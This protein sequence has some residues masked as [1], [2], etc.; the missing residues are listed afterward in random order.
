MKLIILVKS[1]GR[2]SLYNSWGKAVAISLMDSAVF[3][4]FALVELVLSMIFETAPI[5]VGNGVTLVSVFLTFIITV[6]YFLIREPLNLGILRWYY[7]I[8][9]GVSEEI[10]NIFSV[11]ASVKQYFR[12]L[13]LEINVWG[14]K[15]IMACY[16]F[17]FPLLLFFVSSECLDS[18]DLYMSADLS[19]IIG[20]AGCLFSALAFVFAFILFLIHKQ[21][22]FLAR[23]YLVVGGLAPIEA[24]KKSKH[25]SKN[26]LGEIL[27][28]KLS[29]M[30]LQLLRL[31]VIPSIYV[32]PYYNASAMIFARVLMEEHYR[33][34]QL[35]VPQNVSEEN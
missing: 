32:K 20:S 19:Y 14:R 3:L 23:Y 7:G 15:L 22:F 5:I 28:F 8:S 4:L 34:T 18:G 10:I 35:V 17:V 31:L 13:C 9:E 26:R 12:S 33:S 27:L 16:Y 25:A 24:I 6:G 30:P 11:F 2:R 21:K 29:F 1:N